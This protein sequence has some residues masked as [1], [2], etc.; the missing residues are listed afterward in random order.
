MADS[1]L[2]SPSELRKLLGYDP[3]TGSLHWLLRPGLTRGERF[4]NTRFAGKKALTSRGDKGYLLGSICDRDAKA[5]RVAWAIYHGQW[6]EGM[7]DHINGDRADN[8]I[9]NLRVVS[10]VENGRNA[11]RPANNTSG[12]VGV[13]WVKA[14][15]RWRSMVKVGGRDIYLGLFEK[16]ADAVEARK[17]AEKRYGFSD[18]H[19]S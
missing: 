5:H 1:D 10:V 16:F 12:A 3:E 17:D 14:K 13:G 15:R 6:P 2:P 11:K 9:A 4:F 8:R 19:G 7:L 18:R